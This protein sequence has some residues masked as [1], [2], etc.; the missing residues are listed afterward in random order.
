MEQNLGYYAAAV[1]IT[2]LWRSFQLMRG[3]DR[4]DGV[5]DF[6]LSLAGELEERIGPVIMVAAAALMAG[7]GYAAAGLAALI[8]AANGLKL[9]ASA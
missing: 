7:D 9:R 3:N 1:G 6:A 8:A 2:L 4:P 5:K